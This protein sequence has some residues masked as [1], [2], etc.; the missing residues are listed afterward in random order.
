MLQ[1][2][3]RLLEQERARLTREVKLKTELEVGAPSSWSNWSFCVCRE[4]S[5]SNGT[6]MVQ[7]ELSV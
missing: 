5:G 4:R 3:V 6:V 7:I 2:E 1:G